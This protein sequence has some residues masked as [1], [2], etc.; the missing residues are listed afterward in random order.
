MTTV[1]AGYT[2]QFYLN[3]GRVLNL[4][5]DT[6]S[7]G[8]WRSKLDGGLQLIGAALLPLQGYIGPFK[9]PRQIQVEVSA[10]AYSF[11]DD[12]FTGIARRQCA[13]RSQIPTGTAAST[14]IQSRTRHILRADING[15]MQIEFPNWRVNGGTGETSTGDISTHRFAIE[16]IS[17]GAIMQ[18]GTFRGAVAGT[19]GPMR[20][21]QSDPLDKLFMKAGDQFWLRNYRQG[22]AGCIFS[23][24]PNNDPNGD[25]SEAGSGLTDKTLSGSIG[26]ATTSIYYPL[27]ITSKHGNPAVLIGGTS[28]PKGA[29]DTLD[30]SSSDQG[31]IARA[32]G[33]YFGYCN[34]G[35]ASDTI[36]SILNS[37]A[38]RYA[39]ANSGY[40]TD[41]FADYVSV[42]DAGGIVANDLASLVT[43]GANLGSIRKHLL[44]NM[45][46][47]T[48][49]DAY[50]TPAY[51][52]Q[53]HNQTAANL[54]YLVAANRGKILGIKNWDETINVTRVVE[55]IYDSGIWAAL[56][57]TD[58][59]HPNLRG[60]LEIANSGLFLPQRLAL[61]LAA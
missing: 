59:T 1:L 49:T 12:R 42:N 2:E 22:T 50:A 38:L 7:A 16:H 15:D 27:T 39:M 43:V 21:I 48:T 10:G 54:T 33:Q 52:N 35:I 3:A 60:N 17:S 14:G 55:A 57:T 47:S 9:Q 36:S 37:G 45:P 11:S 51:I 46:K 41:Y 5:G 6:N 26:S 58:G 29:G 61:A 19:C 30:D 20:Q 18:Q 31:F 28:I 4:Q 25:T 13:T 40:F 24:L 56:R 53:A 23:T 8:V 44:T 32:Y 34:G